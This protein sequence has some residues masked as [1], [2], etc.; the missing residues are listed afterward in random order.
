MDKNLFNLIDAENIRLSGSQI[1]VYKFE[2][3]EDYDDVYMES[4]Q[5]A[6]NPT[7]V[8][9]WGHFDPRALEENLTQFGV[10][11]QND[12]TFIFNKSYL[13]DRL[14]RGVIAGDILKPKFLN[15]KYQIHEVQ[16]DS[17]EAYGVYHLLAHAKV[18]RDTDE[19]HDEDFF[20]LTDNLGGR[21]RG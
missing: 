2:S 5:K 19:I 1:L 6:I 8:E 21:P 10:E 12:Q 11:V 18:L 9:V 4:R 7:P 14:G 15:M 3:S 17:F 16:E 13:E 20:D